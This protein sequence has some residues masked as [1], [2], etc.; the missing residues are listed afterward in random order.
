MARI[1]KIGPS[2]SVFPS[3]DDLRSLLTFRSK[4][5]ELNNSRIGTPGLNRKM[6][7]DNKVYLIEDEKDH[8]DAD[9]WSTLL[10]LCRHLNSAGCVLWTFR[11][12]EPLYFGLEMGQVLKESCDGFLWG[13]ESKY[14]DVE[15]LNTKIR[16]AETKSESVPVKLTFLGLEHQWAFKENYYLVG[17]EFTEEQSGLLVIEEY[18]KERQFFERLKRKHE[19]GANAAGQTRSRIP[20][21]VRIE[22]WRR[23]GGKCAKCGSREMLEYDHI[24]PVS[25]GGGSTARNVELLCE[26]CNRSK[27][28]RIE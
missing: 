7:E 12:L 23:D 6:V 17:N 19:K 8:T 2:Q 26:T 11:N 22:V 28:A 9:R 14:D 13:W 20:E 24:V 1:K 5:E 16:Q 27:G 21:Q 3:L 15:L 10:A 25:R 4:L 18:D